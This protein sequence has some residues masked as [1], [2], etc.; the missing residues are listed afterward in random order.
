[1]LTTT[2]QRT[3]KQVE[4]CEFVCDDVISGSDFRLQREKELTKFPDFIV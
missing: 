3:C 1:M 2:M 4:R